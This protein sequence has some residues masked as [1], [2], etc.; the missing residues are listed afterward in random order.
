MMLSIFPVL[1]VLPGAFKLYQLIS[2]CSKKVAYICSQIIPLCVICH[3]SPLLLQTTGKKMAAEYAEITIK[4]QRHYQSSHCSSAQAKIA[5]AY[6]EDSMMPLLLSEL[7]IYV[8]AF[9]LPPLFFWSIAGRYC[10]L[11]LTCAPPP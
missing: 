2:L 9:H 5:G 11:R 3:F 8:K 7:P 4:P 1:G 10:P 6:A